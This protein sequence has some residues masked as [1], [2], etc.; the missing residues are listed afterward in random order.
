MASAQLVSPSFIPHPDELSLDE[1]WQLALRIASS[2]LFSK[3]TQLRE[4][5]LYITRQWLLDEN[6]VI[7]E[8]E[9]ACRVLGRRGDFNPAEDNIVRVQISHLRRKLDEYFKGPGAEELLKLTIPRGSYAPHFE[10]QTPNPQPAMVRTPIPISAEEAGDKLHS[11]AGTAATD[12]VLHP[13]SKTAILRNKG[14]LGLA[15]AIVLLAAAAYWTRSSSNPAV[16]ASPTEAQNPFI[17]RIFAPDQPVSIVVADTNLVVLQNELHTDISIGDYVSRDYPENI[18]RLEKNPDEHAFLKG[19]ALRRF[20]SLADVH[21]SSRCTELA[22]RFGSKPTIT[23]ARNMNA[24]DF[25]HGN[26]V[27]IGSRTADPWVE[28]FEPQLNFA[29]EQDP[30]T[31]TFHFRNKHPLPGEQ[32][33]YVPWSRHDDST[34]SYVDV[35]LVPNLSRTGYVLLL[36]AATMDANEAAMRLVLGRQLPDTLSNLLAS[37]P[38]KSTFDTSFEIF[39][40][41]HAVNGVVSSYDVLSVRKIG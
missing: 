10:T 8:Q 40:Q 35:A 12:R 5:L 31:H 30:A 1:R 28:L 38:K 36:N 23:Y 21:V 9:I 25:E 33:T 29:Y 37:D 22:D 24:R 11:E 19:L 14:L 3:A 13:V 18:L 15:A 4:I 2:P 27:L 26:F 32:A 6:V 16:T 7:K 20:T 17:T 41:D 34:T 39:L